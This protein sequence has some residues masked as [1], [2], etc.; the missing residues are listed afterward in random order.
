MKCKNKQ[1]KK[2]TQCLILA[3]ILLSA[4]I[5]VKSSLMEALPPEDSFSVNQSLGKRKVVLFVGDTQRFG[6]R[7]R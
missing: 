4:A 1:T 3:K 5:L 2:N 7:K 6:A